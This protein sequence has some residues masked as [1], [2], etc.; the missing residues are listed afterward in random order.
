MKKFFSL[1]LVL[2]MAVACAFSFTACAK[3]KS[4]LSIG[5]QK[6][7]TGESYVKGDADWGFAGIANST[8]SSYDTI[9]GAVT[10]M[11]NG[12][13]DYIIVDKAVADS[14][15]AQYSNDVK[16]INVNLTVEEYAIGVN[17]NK[18]DL[19]TSVNQIIADMKTDGTLDA[20]YAAYANVGEEG[21]EPTGSVYTGVTSGNSSAENKL[22][23]ATNAAFAPYEYKIGS[24]FY[25]IDM[26]I[27]KVIA[28]K[29]NMELIISDMKFDAVVT[30]VNNG[31]SDLALACL[32]VNAVRSKSVNFSAAYETGA[33][34]VL[35]VKKGDTSF[36]N[37][38]TV[39]EIL[40]VFA[41]KK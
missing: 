11:K 14:L 1:I 32:T 17:K 20:I 35:V 38:K 33:A 26:E 40:N 25:G 31:D 41:S 36:D 23:V 6:G 7:T 24:K 3:D 4:T 15:A 39:D 5:V 9:V 29:L 18:S 28:T 12:N 2:T 16:V 22:I 21:N 30:S 19:L 13:L 27:A 37:C 8:V 34:Q 10:D